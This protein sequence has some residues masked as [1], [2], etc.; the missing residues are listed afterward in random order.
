[1]MLKSTVNILANLILFVSL[2]IGCSDNKLDSQQSTTKKTK[3]KIVLAYAEWTDAIV[4]THVMK[5]ILETHG[6]EVSI[7]S[8]SIDKV[9]TMVASGE[10]DAMVTAWLPSTHKAY[11]EQFQEKIENLGPNLSGTRLGLV[12]PVYVKIS[13]IT[14]L[15]NA[16]DQFNG[17]IHGIEPTAGLMKL[18]NQAIKD[19]QLNYQVVSNTSA[20][21]LNKLEQSIDQKSYIVITGW[22]P[23]WKFAKFELKYLADPKQ[24]FGKQEFIHSIANKKFLVNNPKASK[25]I[26][27]FEWTTSDIAQVM[28]WMNKGMPPKDAAFKWQSSRK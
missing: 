17:I 22:T 9:W 26:D 21:M 7:V 12:V 16:S 18:T 2:L 23:H 3:E 14:E 15:N 4:T 6:Y 28:V 27:D 8:A 5:L 25:I 1:M 10:A 11:L 13:S 20:S 24:V 19:Y